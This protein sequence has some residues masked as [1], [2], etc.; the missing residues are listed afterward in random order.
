VIAGPDPDD[1]ATTA[2]RDHVAA[3]Y[4]AS[5]RADGLK[6]RTHRLCCTRPTTRD[7]R[8]RRRRRHSKARSAS[9]AISA[10]KVIDPVEVAGL[11][12]MRRSPG[13]GCNEFKY[14]L[15]QLHRS[16][17]R[18]GADAL[19]RGHHQ[20]APL[21]SSIPGAAGRRAGG[22]TTS[23]V[24]PP[25]CQAREAF[26]EKLR[27]AVL[28][29]MDA[30]QLDALAYPTWSNPAAAH[31]RSQHARAA[32][33]ASSFRRAP[34]F[35]RSPC[36]WATR[37]ATRCRPG[38]SIPRPALERKHPPH[39]RLRLRAGDPPSPSAAGNGLRSGE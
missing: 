35:R 32:T 13:G 16:A 3:S 31:R 24:R 7:A 29:L 23:P 15:R 38:C 20:I 14:D 19:A 1:P 21:S 10:P 17:R 33:T 30:G 28:R 37:A 12:Y 11:D 2:G 26:R 5:L 39:A 34:V 9:C 4:A 18:Q 25:G 36:R 22:P 27:V 6:G 8:S